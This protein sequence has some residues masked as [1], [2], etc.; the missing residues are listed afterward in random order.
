[1]A[2]NP[3]PNKQEARTADIAIEQRRLDSLDLEYLGRK[4]PEYFRNILV[5]IGFCVS[6][7]GSML[8]TEYFV[9][10]SN[11]ILPILEDALDIPAQAKTWPASVFSLVT[12]AFLLP[13]ARLADLYGAN[14]IFNAGLIWF[15]LWSFVG[16]WS[17]NYRMLIFCRALQGLGPAS[18]LPAGVKLLGTIYRPGPRKN[19][20]FSLYGAFSPIGF[21]SGICVSGLTGHYLT[22]RWYFWIGSIPLLVLSV[23]SILTLPSTRSSDKLDTKMDWLGLCTIVPG[24]LLLVYALTDSSHA[25]DGWRS[26]YIIVTFILGIFC[27]C[28]AFYIEGWVAT[29]PL[30]P[31]DLFRVKYMSSLFI[32]LLFGYG[33]F[34]VYLFYASFYIETVLGKNSLTTAVW[35]S[36]MAAGGII[37]ATIGGFT[38]HL[39]PGKVLLLLSGAG[40][41]VCVLLFALIPDDPN[42]WAYVFP[43]MIGATAGVD[44]AYSV[45]NIFITTNLPQDRQGVAGAVINSIVFVGISLFLGVADIVVSQTESL[46]PKG[47][48]KAAFWFGVGL[49]GAALVLLLFVKVGRAESALT[50]EERER[51]DGE[52]ISHS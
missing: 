4:R 51:D 30:L 8:I 34:G 40:Y 32:A 43:A 5:E 47:S 11:T 50:V 12:G 35:F 21:Y 10:G 23:L 19:L 29:S 16:G 48:Y 24:L 41:T 18:F 7:L 17:T 39:L 33:V 46:G 44:I 25:P 37:L 52:H 49:G 36:P 22:W 9:S 26:P 28:A 1:M 20:V 13:A 42:Y 14:L 45:S 3:A 2:I 27:L 38:L 6:L 31:F 15:L